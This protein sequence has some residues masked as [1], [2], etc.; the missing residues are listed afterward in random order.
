MKMVPEIVA[1]QMSLFRMFTK[2][3]SR[4][5]RRNFF[6]E[7]PNDVSLLRVAIFISG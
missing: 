5:I 3:K 4:K 1:E 2:I 7:F 6:H